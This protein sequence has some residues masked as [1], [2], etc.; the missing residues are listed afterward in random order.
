[1]VGFLLCEVEIF[2]DGTMNKS[3]QACAWRLRRIAADLR[4]LDVCLAAG[5]SQTRYSTLERGEAEATE[6][7]RQEIEL[8]LPPLSPEIVEQILCGGTP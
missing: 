3:T 4:Q 5:I 7:E 6:A 2:Y 8:A 1:M